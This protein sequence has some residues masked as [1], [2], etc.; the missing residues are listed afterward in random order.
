M[1][2]EKK[3]NEERPGRA[4]MRGEYEKERKIIKGMKEGE[5]DQ[6]EDWT[7]RWRGRRRRR[8][9]ERRRINPE[10]K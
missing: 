6:K 2:M 9:E 1:K 7:R 5:E 3:G 8:A 4:A 10:D